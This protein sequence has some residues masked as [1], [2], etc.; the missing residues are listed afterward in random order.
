MLT[1]EFELAYNRNLSKPRSPRI[2]FPSSPQVAIHYS[3]NNDGVPIIWWCF[4]QR[5]LMNMS[6]ASQPT[7][8]CL[9]ST[10]IIHSHYNLTKITFLKTVFKMSLTLA[11]KS[12]PYWFTLFIWR[13]RK[14]IPPRQ[15][16]SRWRQEAR[17][18]ILNLEEMWVVM[19]DFNLNIK[20]R[21]LLLMVWRT[22]PSTD[23]CLSG[24]SRE[25]QSL[26]KADET[27]LH[28]ELVSRCHGRLPPKTMKK[29]MNWWKEM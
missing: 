6:R 26:I 27:H 10:L 1:F 16:K 20:K 8:E 2:C 18:V 29:T 21:E 13:E 19:Q 28:D 7:K 24:H 3:R 9:V 14:W 11:Y 5:Y 25:S 4:C 17:W 12:L 22:H 15:R 23:I